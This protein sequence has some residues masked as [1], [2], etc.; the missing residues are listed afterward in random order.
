[1]NKS[2]LWTRTRKKPLTTWTWKKPSCS[3]RSSRSRICKRRSRSWRIGPW[4]WRLASSPKS[5]RSSRW[6]RTCTIWK[7][8]ST[9][10]GS[11]SSR[12][13]PMSRR[14]QILL[15]PL[16]PSGRKPGSTQRRK[17]TTSRS[18]SK[19]SES[20][21]KIRMM[22]TSCRHSWLFTANT[23]KSSRKRSWQ[24]SKRTLNWLT[25]STSISSSAKRRSGSFKRIVSR[26]T[27]NLRKSLLIARRR[28]RNWSRCSGKS[29]KKMTC[30]SRSKLTL[31]RTLQKF[32]LKRGASMLKL[33]ACKK[34]CRRWSSMTLLSQASTRQ[35]PFTTSP[36]R[37]MIV[38]LISSSATSLGV[39]LSEVPSLTIALLVCINSRFKSCLAVSM[40]LIRRLSCKTCRSRR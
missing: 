30:V 25:N 21:C 26:R 33:I 2:K 12:W 3:S 40:K 13:R 9:C 20:L 27:R 11:H 10:R 23:L 28:I 1:M 22:P 24:R 32:S 38:S 16:R 7:S 8:Y 15:R 6:S 14:R 17:S 4:R 18:S 34:K 5:N 36:R 39:V 35:V 29:V 19:R 37:V 31:T